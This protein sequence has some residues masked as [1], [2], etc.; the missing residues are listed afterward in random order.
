[1]SFASIKH[2][3]A[4]G[5]STI[6]SVI[7]LILLSALISI[8]PVQGSDAAVT[9]TESLVVTDI[10]PSTG[11]VQDTDGDPLFDFSIE[12]SGRMVSVIISNS[13]TSRG[14]AH[15]DNPN[16]T[17]SSTEMRNFRDGSVYLGG[18]WSIGEGTH[19]GY[20]F[21]SS[22]SPAHHDEAESPVVEFT[23]TV[24]YKTVYTHSTSITFNYNYSGSPEPY[25]DSVSETV[26][27]PT[28]DKEVT[29]EMPENPVRGDD[30]VFMGWATTSTGNP[31][32]TPDVTSVTLAAGQDLTLYAV[33][34]EPF[35]TIT[36]IVDG[37]SYDSVTVPIGEFTSPPED[38]SAPEGYIF[39]GWFRDQQLTEQFEFGGTL[40]SDI[41]LYAKWQE[42]LE[43]T[44]K[45]TADYNVTPIEGQERTFLFSVPAS[46]GA[47]EV[48]WDFGDGNESTNSAVTHYYEDS[49][50]YHVTL[51][52]TNTYGSTVTEFDVQAKGDDG[53]DDIL[54][55]IAVAVVCIT[56][57]AII[58]TRFV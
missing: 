23:V 10:E 31:V 37:E 32:Y 15:L 20:L 47:T 22:T 19:T 6:L 57:A 38:P 1:M 2:H 12:S 40:E 48:H 7:V 5:R 54:I 30:L 34:E 43:F 49:G 58:L 16:G 33:W 42:E 17:Y 52:L 14:Y 27:Q 11:Q 3:T 35:H 53:G 4:G 26:T 24:G 45:P 41:T 13:T 21:W 25:V 8:I 28:L 56:V 18:S 44:S 9:E 29:F 39:A 46:A 36:F 50:T 51:T 55:Y